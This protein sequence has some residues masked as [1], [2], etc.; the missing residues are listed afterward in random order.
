MLDPNE[1]SPYFPHSTYSVVLNVDENFRLDNELVQLQA[2]DDDGPNENI[3]YSIV[4]ESRSKFVIDS[5]GRVFAAKYFDFA[6]DDT[7][8]HNVTVMAM[9][10][11]GHS[12]FTNLIVNLNITLPLALRQHSIFE[13]AVSNG[14]RSELNGYDRRS[15]SPRLVI[16]VHSAAKLFY[17]IEKSMPSVSELVI[18]EQT[19]VITLNQPLNYSISQNYLK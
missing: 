7:F 18:D 16:G 12:N 14:L 4:G 15:L 6:S 17:I 1:H 3:T 19:G 2:Y 10:K 5:M 9:D 13:C 8:M 11:A